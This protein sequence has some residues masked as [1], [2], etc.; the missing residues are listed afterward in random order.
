VNSLKST[1]VL[2]YPKVTRTADG[3]INLTFPDSSAV[4]PKSYSKSRLSAGFSVSSA[5]L[6]SSIN[7][8]EET[9][10]LGTKQVCHSRSL[11]AFRR[12]RKQ[13]AMVRQNTAP[14]GSLSPL[15]KA[16]PPQKVADEQEVVERNLQ[17]WFRGIVQSNHDLATAL[18]RLRDSYQD[19]LLGRPISNAHRAVLIGVEITLRNAENVRELN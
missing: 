19:L 4:S 7:P 13:P 12:L 8:L 3:T 10:E 11:W 9:L 1:L 2:L 17:E 18:E 15:N 16:I 5:S 6:Q 14:Q